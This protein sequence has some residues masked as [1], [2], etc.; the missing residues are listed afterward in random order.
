M[1]MK[2]S[3][4]S[5]FI[6]SLI[7]TNAYAVVTTGT[8]DGQRISYATDDSNVSTSTSL[9]F[10]N[11]PGMARTIAIP[12][13]T[14]TCVAINF[15]TAAFIESFPDGIWIRATRDGAVC[16]P[17][18]LVLTGTPG[19]IDNPSYDWNE[20]A[21]NFICR[22]ITPG[23]HTFRIQWATAEGARIPTRGRAM[24]IHHR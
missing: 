21:A 9:D 5:L 14:S 3:L 2:F 17:G 11:M 22:G 19:L 16:E 15:S 13:T 7:A 4:V 8:C 10:V 20:Y 1:I 6:A 12:G 23:N 24:I 18:S